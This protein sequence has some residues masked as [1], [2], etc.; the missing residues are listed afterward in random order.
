MALVFLIGTGRCGSTLVHE[1]LARHEAFGFV[2][3]IEDNVRHLNRLGRLNRR[4]YRSPLGWQTRKGRIR[5]APSEA[6]A[7]IAREVSPIYANT[8]RDLTAAD[9]TPWLSARFERFFRDRIQAQAVDCFLH[10]Y[11][12]WPRLGFFHA[13]FPEARFVHIV[14]DGRA[15][16]NSWLQMPW[17]NGYRGPENWLWGALPS[18]LQSQ[19][20]HE[21]RSFVALAGIAWKLLIDAAQETRAGLPE[22]RFLEVRFEDFLAE[23]LRYTNAILSFIGVQPNAGFER[24]LSRYEFSSVRN[25]AFETDLARPQVEC[26]NRLIGDQLAAYGYP[27]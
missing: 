2:S 6:Y 17:W 4:L 14:R 20:E 22:S 19:W 11:T 21:G 1:I 27:T 15:V 8:C 25:R 24:S 9:A 13:I 23:P 26:L 12:G 3:N 16:A 5:F 18:D 10:K 7:I